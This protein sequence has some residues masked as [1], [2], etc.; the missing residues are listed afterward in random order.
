MPS[1]HGNLSRKSVGSGDIVSVPVSVGEY[2]T[3]LVPLGF[4]GADP[5]NQIFEMGVLGCLVILNENDGTSKK[6]VAAGYNALVQAFEQEINSIIPTLASDS[7]IDSI[8]QNAIAAALAKRIEAAIRSEISL[9][10]VASLNGVDDFDIG[11]YVAIATHGRLAQA[12]VDG[13]VVRFTRQLGK[14]RHGR[15]RI[16]GYATSG[17]RPKRRVTIA[18]NPFGTNP[19]N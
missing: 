16:S 12:S 8:D 11:H 9:W 6:A 4:K 2:E 3:R 5:I 17:R 14:K 10:D 1:G 13:S 15:W 18:K 7:S 19:I